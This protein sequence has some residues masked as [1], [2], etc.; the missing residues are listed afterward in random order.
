MTM[1]TPVQRQPTPLSTS[2]GVEESEPPVKKSRKRKQA[3]KKPVP[4]SSTLHG[5]WGKPKS[6][7]G[8]SETQASST[9]VTEAED[10]L[11]DI[12]RVEQPLHFKID[13]V[14]LAAAIESVNQAE[15]MIT[16][17]RSLPDI[18]A[19]PPVQNVPDVPKTPESKGSQRKHSLPQSPSEGVR[20][21]PRNHRPSAETLPTSK[22]VKDTKKSHPF[23]LG[24]EARMCLV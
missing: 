11:L 13:P 8:N 17:P 20:R 10:E 2:A 9:V 18:I 1:T 3:E 4:R 19:E 7:D 21:S 6:T 16:P 14:K 23:F 22:P 5:L 12:V 15:R 24:K